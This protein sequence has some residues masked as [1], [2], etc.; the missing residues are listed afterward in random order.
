MS[1]NEILEKLKEI[2]RDVFDEEKLEI[3]EKTTP[4]DVE[5]W[6]SLGHVYLTVE[7]E[8]EFSITFDEEIKRIENVK[9]IVDLIMKQLGEKNA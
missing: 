7:I 3:T 9:D 8:D 4:Q 2:F 1:R 6:N 5:D